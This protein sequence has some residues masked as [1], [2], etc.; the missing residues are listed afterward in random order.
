MAAK[1]QAMGYEAYFYEPATGG[2]S[3]GK[4]NSER[5]AL[6]RLVIIFCAAPSVGTPMIPARASFSAGHV[7]AAF[8]AKIAIFRTRVMS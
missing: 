4:D 5:A 1:L 8:E 7:G 6:R 3:A 2:H